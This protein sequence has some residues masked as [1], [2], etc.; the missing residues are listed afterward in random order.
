[1]ADVLQPPSFRYAIVRRPQ[2]GWDV[3]RTP[4]DDG[5]E[6]ALV[7]PY[8]VLLDAADDAASAHHE[9]QGNLL[10]DGRRGEFRIPTPSRPRRLTLDP[11]QETLAWFHAADQHPKH[12]LRYAAHDVAR[13]GRVGEAEALLRRALE[14]LE[15]PVEAPPWSAPVAPPRREPAVEDARIR[16]DLARLYLDTDRDAEAAEELAWIDRSIDERYW[17]PY[18][19]ERE[20]LR[21]RIDLRAGEHAAALRRLRRLLRAA[22]P[23]AEGSQRRGRAWWTQSTSEQQALVEAFT[24]LAV[25]AHETG[26]TDDLAWAL[27]ETRALAV[28]TSVLLGH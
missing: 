7:V 11:Q 17:S 18:R 12:V 19:V 14:A 20:M 26:A 2:G 24:L 4:R 6:P 25:A 21:A 22:A 13:S 15:G 8:R 10:I 28:D 3:S 9:R 16:L 5:G 23:P 27:D 1:V